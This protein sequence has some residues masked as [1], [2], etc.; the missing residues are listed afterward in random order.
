MIGPVDQSRCHTQA[1]KSKADDKRGDEQRQGGTP[2]PAPAGV[3]QGEAEAEQGCQRSKDRI[4]KTS[5]VE[6][7]DDYVVNRQKCERDQEYPH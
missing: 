7:Q 2:V 1:F 4:V 3:Q 5:Q 6:V